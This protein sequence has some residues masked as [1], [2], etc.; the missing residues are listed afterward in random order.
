MRQQSAWLCQV[1][2]LHCW[3]DGRCCQIRMQAASLLSKPCFCP[4][5]ALMG[6]GAAGGH[7]CP[8]VLSWGWASMSRA[9]FM[10][11]AGMQGSSHTPWAGL[12]SKAPHVVRSSRALLQLAMGSLCCPA[13]GHTLP[14]R[15]PSGPWSDSL[16]QPLTHTSPEHAAHPFPA[17]PARSSPAEACAGSRTR[18]GSLCGTWQPAVL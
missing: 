10:G 16:P 6:K 11:P 17:P 12:G 18:T 14:P 7:G 9:A 2:S 8:C 4:G 5:P 15:S 13:R 1:F 3:S